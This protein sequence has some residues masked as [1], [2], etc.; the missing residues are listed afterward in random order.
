MT[1]WTA[2]S[3]NTCGPRE[4]RTPPRLMRGPRTRAMRWS[5]RPIWAA[6][7]DSLHP[8]LN[9]AQPAG[10][11]TGDAPSGD[12]REERSRHWL[13]LQSRYG[14]EALQSWMRECFEE[15]RSSAEWLRG[16]PVDFEHRRSAIRH[17]HRREAKVA[18]H[19]EFHRAIVFFTVRASCIWVICPLFAVA[20]NVYRAKK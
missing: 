2:I 16:A 3:V 4:T 20:L 15:Y 1:H 11:Y 12:L 13:L 7:W 9:P 18:D 8:L 10:G 6:Y 19:D 14:L 17:R 5:L